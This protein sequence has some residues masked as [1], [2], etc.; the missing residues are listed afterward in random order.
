MCFSL[1]VPS[2]F[3][4]ISVGNLIIKSLFGSESI[5]IPFPP[6]LVSTIVVHFVAFANAAD[7]SEDE[8]T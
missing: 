1:A 7:Y 3:I 6:V 4:P 2:G 5:P 8:Y